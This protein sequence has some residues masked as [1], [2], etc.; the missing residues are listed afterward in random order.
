MN[1]QSHVPLVKLGDT[2][3][4]LVDPA[5]DI[6]GRAVVGPDG[7]KFGKVDGLFLDHDEAKVRLLEI[8]DGGFLGLGKE[9]RLVPVELVRSVDEDQVVIE[10][11]RQTVIGAPAYDPELTD[12][13]EYFTNVYDYYEVGPF[14][15][16]GALYRRP[17]YYP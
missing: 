6:R 5:D 4:V 3:L 2:D 9:S 14:W 16:P 12:A 7:E 15:A 13:P 17:P 8:V 11:D 10:R 1:E